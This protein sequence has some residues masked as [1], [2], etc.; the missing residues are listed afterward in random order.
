[1]KKLIIGLVL[2]ALLLCFGTMADYATFKKNDSGDA[3]LTIQ[4]ALFKLNYLSE[5]YI[6]GEFDDMTEL[7]VYAFQLDQN[8]KATGIAD[9]YTQKALYKAAGISNEIVT[10]N[11][12]HDSDE[13]DRYTNTK[14]NAS[15]NVEV[16]TVKPTDNGVTSLPRNEQRVTSAPLAKVTQSA[17]DMPETTGPVKKDGEASS[18]LF[19]NSIIGLALIVFSSLFLLRPLFFWLTHQSPLTDAQVSQLSEARKCQYINAHFQFTRK[20]FSVNPQ[21]RESLEKEGRWDHISIDY[22]EIGSAIA[23]LLRYKRHEWF[24]WILAN[25]SKAQYLWANKG[26]DNAS[27]YSKAN[28]PRLLLL[29]ETTDCNTVIHFHNHPH[30]KGRYWNLLQ[31][32]ETDMD[33]CKTL[34]ELFDS[35]DLNF[36]DGLVSQ[37]DFIVFGYHFTKRYYPSGC[38]V[39]EIKKENGINKAKNYKLHKELRKIRHT[40]IASTLFQ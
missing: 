13:I 8:I 34:T 14:P 25:D 17:D 28:M 2:S 19:R 26:D 3:V 4:K 18:L 29:A 39:E 30:T 33:T 35:V 10:G 5:K 11:D 22:A 7:A 16:A 15:E 38:S 21:F 6:S 40:K 32:S 36:I 37:G 27:C 12:H 1:M 24:I 20:T 9:P 23:E 31:P